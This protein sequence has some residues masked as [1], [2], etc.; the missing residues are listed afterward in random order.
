MFYDSIKRKNIYENHFLQTRFGE[1]SYKVKSC[2]DILSK[3]KYKDNSSE[4]LKETFLLKLNYIIEN[5]R[6]LDTKIKNF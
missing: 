3:M 1:I 5:K 4:N 2:Y 6:K